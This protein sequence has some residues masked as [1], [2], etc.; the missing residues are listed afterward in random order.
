MIFLSS[1]LLSD[2]SQDDVKVSNDSWLKFYLI[3]Y[4][5]SLKFDE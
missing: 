2:L 3:L 5:N 4:Y 1:Y